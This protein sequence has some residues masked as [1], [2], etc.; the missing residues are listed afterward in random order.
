MRSIEEQIQD[1]ISKL[2]SVS[3]GSLL[4]VLRRRLEPVLRPEE[5]QVLHPP[6]RA[7][8]QGL[9]AMYP[10][11]VFRGGPQGWRE[12][13]VAA[14]IL[15]VLESLQGPTRAIQDRVGL[16]EAKAFLQ[17]RKQANYGVFIPHVHPAEPSF[18]DFWL[19]RF[20]R[21]CYRRKLP[22]GQLCFEHRPAPDVPTAQA[23][24][25][26]GR[27]LFPSFN[28]HVRCLTTQEVWRFHEA[29]LDLNVLY[30]KDQALRWLA[31]HRPLVFAQL[32]VGAGSTLDD[33]RLWRMVISHL[34]PLPNDGVKARAEQQAAN[35]VFLA[36]TQL[37]W[38]VL[39]RA[40]AWFMADQARRAHWGGVRKNAGRPPM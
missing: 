39:V 28:E 22:G 37:L 26:S 13:E 18:Q 10:A 30:P 33:T 40:E 17:M 5:Q 21:L 12:H 4:T 35:Q 1:D 11:F 34:Q 32:G 14:V 15:R 23:R 16:Y 8:W 29:E 38:P 24:Y 3:P 31:Q 6:G 36:H 9:W 2:R 19:Y 7:T 25:Q 20:C 27:R